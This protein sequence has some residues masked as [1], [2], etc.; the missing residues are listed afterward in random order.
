MYFIYITFF[1]FYLNQAV[2]E[3]T[4]NNG[5][6]KDKKNLYLIIFISHKHSYKPVNTV[7]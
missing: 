6:M 4:H 5:V 1:L 7:N 2:S 3:Y